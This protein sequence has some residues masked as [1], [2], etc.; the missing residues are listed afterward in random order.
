MRQLCREEYS[1]DKESREVWGSRPASAEVRRKA[2]PSQADLRRPPDFTGIG[3]IEELTFSYPAAGLPQTEGDRFP[4]DT[5]RP[6]ADR[7]KG[8]EHMDKQQQLIYRME[9]QIGQLIRM[10]ASLNERVAQLEQLERTHTLRVIHTKRL[11]RT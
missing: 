2:A 7:Q 11:T 1:E 5:R 10:V 9:L 8:D 3:T 4:S 6:R